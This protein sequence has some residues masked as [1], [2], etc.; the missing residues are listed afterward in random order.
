MRLKLC[1][2]GREESRE[3][4]REGERSQ[5]RE[6]EREGGRKG[7][8]K[9]GREGGVKG[10]RARRE[11]ERRR[12]EDDDSHQTHVI[13]LLPLDHNYIPATYNETSHQEEGQT[14]VTHH[15]LIY[16]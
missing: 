10:G 14:H 12:K 7:G 15:P 16:H 1:G 6:G 9:G 8:V 3:E 4:G 5:G 2:R 13:N 11:D